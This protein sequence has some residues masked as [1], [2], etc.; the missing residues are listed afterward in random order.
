MTAPRDN[1]PRKA[2]C[3]GAACGAA[4]LLLFSALQ[5]LTFVWG[6]G[7]CPKPNRKLHLHYQDNKERAYNST[8]KSLLYGGDDVPQGTKREGK[9]SGWPV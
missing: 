5:A 8:V 6:D 9:R 2:L 3:L 7:V 1:V 4:L